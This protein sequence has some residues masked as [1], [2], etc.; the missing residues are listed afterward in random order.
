MSLFFDTVDAALREICSPTCFSCGRGCFR[1]LCGKCDRFEK[2]AGVNLNC[3]PL[4]ATLSKFYL[5]SVAQKILHR[6]KLGREY[7]WLYHFESE[8]VLDGLDWGPKDC[9]IPVPLH[10][11]RFANRTFNQSEI[12]ARMLAERHGLA[13][14]RNFLKKNRWTRPQSRLTRF[15][16]GRNLRRAFSCALSPQ[17]PQSVILVDDVFTTGATLMACCHAL[18]RAGVERVRG[19]TL[20]RTPL[21]ILPVGTA[22]RPDSEF[23]QI[24]K[25]PQMNY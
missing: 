8:C 1:S 21:F 5:N 16:R 7:R 9:L 20:F 15:A 10:R 22:P 11:F 3:I 17:P 25:A 13:M 18:K 24:E 23:G 19:W 6:V 4:E 2:T 14:D 12:L